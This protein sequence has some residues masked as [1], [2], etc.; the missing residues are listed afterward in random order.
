VDRWRLASTLH[1]APELCR[2]HEVMEHITRDKRLGILLPVAFECAGHAVTGV[3]GNISRRGVYVRTDAGVEKDEIIKLGITLPNGLTVSVTSMA[4]H[5]LERNAAQALGRCAGVGFRF[6]DEDS[7]GVRA[8]ADLI[9]ELEGEVSPSVED[10]AERLRLV[11]ASGDPRLLDRMTTV[12]GESGYSVEAASSSFEAYVLSAEYRPELIVVG[13]YMAALNGPTL[14]V[15]VAQGKVEF[16]ILRLQKPFTDEELCAQVA[17]ALAK[18][19]RR[20][21]MRASLHDIPLGSLLSFLESTRKTGVVTVSRGDRLVELHIRDGHIV[22]LARAGTADAR[23]ILFEL[24]DWDDGLFQFFLCPI[25][26]P[27]QVR[28]STE[29]LLLEHARTRDEL[30]ASA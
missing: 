1:R 27:D 10:V 25:L 23:S 11:V 13:E 14:A 15:D 9:L 20:S 2:T 3:A 24:L 4:V 8:I 16:K 12:L 17:A 29:M 6:L 30:A 26:D 7:P 28:C 18:A 22:S 5:S 19:V 21:S